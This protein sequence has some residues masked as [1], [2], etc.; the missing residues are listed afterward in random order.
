MTVKTNRLR[1]VVLIFTGV[2]VTAVVV[3]RPVIYLWLAATSLQVIEEV[4][5]LRN[6]V[7]DRCFTVY[8][9]PNTI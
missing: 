1:N 9:C 4:N 7:L 5:E 3:T 2:A 8:P 6:H